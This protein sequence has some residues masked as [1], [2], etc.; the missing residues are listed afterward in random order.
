M[1]WK[2]QGQ[3][4]TRQRN[5]SSEALCQASNHSPSQS[6]NPTPLHAA[7]NARWPVNYPIGF[8]GQPFQG[9]PRSIVARSP[10]P[11]QMKVTMG[12]GDYHTL[13]TGVGVYG[14]HIQYRM[15][16]VYDPYYTGAGPWSRS[17]RVLPRCTT[18]TGSTNVTGRSP[19]LRR[20]IRV[21]LCARSHSHRTRRLA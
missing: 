15:N 11:L 17:T 8:T 18:A 14:S 16:S 19:S 12:Y 6:C 21:T 9:L 3:T 20:V 7:W 4:K 13:T 2:G 5:A 1:K 10:W